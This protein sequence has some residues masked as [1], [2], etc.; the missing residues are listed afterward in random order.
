MHYEHENE[1][2]RKVNIFLS[3]SQTPPKH[4][5]KHIYMRVKRLRL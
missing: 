5:K 3:F 1:K 2:L 4:I